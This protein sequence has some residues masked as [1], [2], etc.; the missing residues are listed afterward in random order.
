MKKVLMLALCLGLCASVA[1]AGVIGVYADNQGLGCSLSPA[2]GIVN[3][4]IMQKFNPGGALAS[5]FKVDDQ[6]GV[7]HIA[8]ATTSPFLLIGDYRAGASVAYTDCLVG[9]IVIAT[10][11]Y[12]YS[13]APAL[14]CASK[15]TVV[16][17]PTASPAT[18]GFVDCNYNLLPVTGG[19]FWFANSCGEC[20]NATATATWGTIKALYK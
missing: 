7:T 5:E 11:T 8:D 16:P 18:L 10:M 17:D 6:S 1:S 2:P 9:D 14:T 13:G 19:M 12:F 4:Y 20:A 15:L 3:L